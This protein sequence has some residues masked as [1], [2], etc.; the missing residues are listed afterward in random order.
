MRLI[1]IIFAL[2][3]V[4]ACS[5]KKEITASDVQNQI[6]YSVVFAITP[7]SEGK[8]TD[9]S[10]AGVRNLRTQE[11]IEMEFTPEFM[12][13]AKRKLSRGLW[14]VNRDESGKIKDMY[15][16]CYYSEAVPNNPICDA[17]FGE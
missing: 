9:I 16:F 4:G 7:D 17:K 14:S 13:S 2:F 15:M 11:K 3:L 10:V 12:E 8:L 6:K 5:S 1:A